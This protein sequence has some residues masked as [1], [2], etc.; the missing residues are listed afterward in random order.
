[1]VADHCSNSG[2]LYRLFG[3]FH[4]ISVYVLSRNIKKTARSRKFKWYFV[5][6]ENSPSEFHG[7]NEIIVSA[8]RV[9]A[10]PSI[11]ELWPFHSYFNDYSVTISS[12][13]Q[14]FFSLEKENLIKTA[15]YLLMSL[16]SSITAKSFLY[17]LKLR[18]F[19][20][21]NDLRPWRN[22]EQIL[23]VSS[24]LLAL[25]HIKPLPQ[26]FQMILFIYFVVWV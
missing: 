22:P 2:T 14:S 19:Y 4:V 1:M 25:T 20:S 6:N 9:W 26:H 5:T 24:F 11:Y 15:I 8:T 21:M 16:K 13:S 3:Q 23:P 10:S 18:V 7:L 12:N 17:L